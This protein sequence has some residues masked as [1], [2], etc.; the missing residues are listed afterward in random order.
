MMLAVDWITTPNPQSGHGVSYGYVLANAHLA[1][2]AQRAGLVFEPG[3]EI[4]LH[5]K[6]PMQFAPIQGA[7]RQALYTMWESPDFPPDLRPHLDAA[8][9]IMVPSRF[10]VEIFR[11]Y[12]RPEVPIV[13]VPLGID[14]LVFRP[15]RRMWQP[16]DSFQWLM[17]GAA[18]AR[19]GWDTLEET[20]HRHFIHRTDCHLYC[21]TTGTLKAL[22]ESIRRGAIPVADRPGVVHYHNMIL[23]F[24]NLPAAELALTY[25]RSHGFV[26]PTAGEGAGLTLLEAMATGLPSIATR[27]SGLLDFADDSVAK[28]VS[29]EP[30]Y[31]TMTDGTNGLVRSVVN[32]AWVP[33]TELADAM[34]WMMAHYRD[35]LMMGRRAAQRVHASWTWDAAGRRLVRV[36]QRF[37]E[38]RPF[39]QAVAA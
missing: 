1:V 21:K 9:L 24:R 15:C 34:G 2:A 27:Y 31:S 6:T 39:P 30:R 12:V 33:P 10:C 38:G 4:A 32:S 36:L 26:F 18:N 23:D 29:W 17:V 13:I 20:W 3:N 11:P 22:S 19:K 25:Q 16:G 35:A 5:V 7:A 28:L 37:A 8:D 14:P